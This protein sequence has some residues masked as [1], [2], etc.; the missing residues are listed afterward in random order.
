MGFWGWLL[1]IAALIVIVL[2][3]VVRSSF[4]QVEAG[5]ERLAAFDAREGAYTYTLRVAGSGR[6]EHEGAVLRV[7]TGDV[8]TLEH[9]EGNK[10]DSHAMR[11]MNG[12]DWLG[13]VPRDKARMVCD[14]RSKGREVAAVV[15]GFTGE[16]DELAVEMRLKFF[17]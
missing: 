6:R 9:D 2:V 3:A 5:N 11:V 15:S 16:G 7:R 10:H 4:R 8:L 1:L 12:I 17:N 13:Y 14:W